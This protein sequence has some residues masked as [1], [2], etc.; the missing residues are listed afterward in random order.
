MC[1]WRMLL[2]CKV[3]FYAMGLVRIFGPLL[4]FGMWFFYWAVGG[5]HWRRRSKRPQPKM[6]N[7]HHRAAWFFLLFPL[8][9]SGVFY[10]GWLLGADVWVNSAVPLST[11]LNLQDMTLGYGGNIL[12][13]RFGLVGFLLDYLTA[14]V[15][16][17]PYLVLVT[18]HKVCM[19]RTSCKCI[20]AHLI[21]PGILGVALLHLTGEVPMLAG[22]LFGATYLCLMGT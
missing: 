15:L 18:F 1:L 5:V 19:S 21:V 12:G 14:T 17:L 7:R 3:E 13:L 2:D 9:L 16:V 4:P 11:A 20:P 8:W 10:V 6:S 22:R